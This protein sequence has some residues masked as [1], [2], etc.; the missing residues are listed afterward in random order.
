MSMKVR[1]RKRARRQDQV[2]Y[3]AS[4]IERYPIVSIEDGMAEDDWEGW[5]SLTEHVEK[6]SQLV[7]DDLFVTNVARLAKGIKDGVAD[8]ILVKVNQI[9]TLTE[10]LAAVEM[11]HRLY[12][13]YVTPLRRNRGLPNRGSGGGNQFGTDQNR[14]ACAFQIA[15]QNITSCCALKMN[16]D[17]RQNTPGVTP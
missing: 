5:K 14:F 6:E 1:G 12:G 3:L 13:R 7:G 9:G 10:T 2:K 15:Q 17:H 11:A 4:L 8:S 16:S